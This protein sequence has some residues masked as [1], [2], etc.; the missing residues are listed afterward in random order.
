MY[1]S[2]ESLIEYIL[3]FVIGIDVASKDVHLMTHDHIK[4][5]IMFDA[6]A[7]LKA[8]FTFSRFA[9]RVVHFDVIKMEVVGIE[10]S[11]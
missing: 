1:L 9:L 11:L 8:R 7:D 10:F 2:R 5:M 6:S 4:P 3:F